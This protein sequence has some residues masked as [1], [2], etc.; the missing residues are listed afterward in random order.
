V[1][2]RVPYGTGDRDPA[3][4]T[5]ENRGAATVG[6]TRREFVRIGVAAGGGLLVAVYLPGCARER[7]GE[8]A[9]TGL[10]EGGHAPATDA[11]AVFE[12]SAWVQIHE[13][14][15]ATI[16]VGNSEMG[17]GVR[18]SLALLV[19]EE[20]D[21]DWE[22]VR[23]AQ[24]PNDPAKYGRQGTGGSASVKTAW[25]PL[26]RAGAAARA[27]LVA[28]AA[29]ALEAPET[30]LETRDGQVLHPASGR[31]LTYA[32]L[33]EHASDLPVPT[34]VA[35]KPRES[36]RLLGREGIVGVDALDIV[37]GRAGY[38]S[39]VS[40]PGM[41]YA[42]VARTPAHGGGIRRY[43]ASAALRVPGVRKVVRVPGQG[44]DVNVHPGIAVLAESS[45]AAIRGRDALEVEWEPGPHGHDT[46]EAFSATM[47]KAVM[48]PGSVTLNRV[49]DP[50]ALI[51]G[52]AP[53]DVVSATYET[54][55]LSHATMEPQTCVAE[56]RDGKARLRS[57]TQFPDWAARATAAALGIP[58]QNV[59]V[60]IPLLGGGYGRRINPDFSVEAALIAREAG[61][62]VKVIWTREDDLR[63]DFYRPCA[64]H[65]FDAVLGQDGYPE[66]WRHRFCTPAISATY[67]PG[68][69]ELQW[70]L[71]EGSGTANMLYRVP[72]R[73]SEYTHLPCGL[74]RG[75][76]RA[77][78]T[79]HGIFARE[80]FMDE[81]AERAGIDP[82]EYR[83]RLI[84]ALQVE[85]PEPDPDFPPDPERL[86]GVLRRAAREAGWGSDLPEGRARGVA[87]GID[88]LGY[89]AEVVEV[90]ALDG[91]FRIDR[92]VAAVDCGPVVNPDGGRAQVEGAIHQ[93][94]SA[95]LGE[96]LTVRDGAVQ[97]GNFDRYRILRIDRAPRGIEVH[98]VETD[99]HPTGLGEPALPPAA[100]ALANALYRLTGRRI[101]SLPIE[102]GA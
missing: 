36:W 99:T 102:A 34:D 27:V 89:A 26:R 66:A 21:L 72:N 11:P 84:D 57:P 20:L 55:F 25:L 96:R 73:T 49:G 31:S 15:S 19:A 44:R 9:G 86:K 97:E 35:P 45:W 79:T 50:D 30:E 2:A 80:C 92:V 75:W 65:H 7:A 78:S 10:L 60:T 71:G 91:G 40:M 77:V 85:R 62:P 4:A 13:D 43:D 29:A 67:E 64:V 33:A 48:G 59:E 101:R 14:N 74:T 46:S 1:S 38:G 95:A 3:R 24:A 56:V 98:F 17:Q 6:V 61:A 83:L 23:I 53:A 51:T 100:P 5:G 39:D 32:E 22:R 47:R 76:W 68:E 81:L 70:G 82:V 93:G 94:L 87:C 18:T 8:P 16:T 52:V 28:A 42:A 54:P 90:S 63:H 12:P 58:K 37:T 69:N 41:L 88:H